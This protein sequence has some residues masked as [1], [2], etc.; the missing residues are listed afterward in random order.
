MYVF[1]KRIGIPVNQV[2]PSVV[3]KCSN[4]GVAS[5]RY[6]NCAN[7]SCNE[8]HF[9]CEKCEPITERFCCQ[10]CKDIIEAKLAAEAKTASET[11]A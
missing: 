2:N 9:L 7:K 1:D 5:E 3:A 10:E 4:C 8:Q 6:V 11:E